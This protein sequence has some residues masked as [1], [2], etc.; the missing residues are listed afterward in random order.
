MS[1]RECPNC[2]HPKDCHDE[3]CIMCE[4]KGEAKGKVK[5]MVKKITGGGNEKGT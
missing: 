3:L 2:G 4:L 5:N 1:C